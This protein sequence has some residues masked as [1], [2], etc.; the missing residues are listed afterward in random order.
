MNDP[1]S[2]LNASFPY[3]PETILASACGQAYV[4]IMLSSGNIGVCSTLNHPVETDPLL[5]EKPDLKRKDHRMLVTAFAN[6]HINYKQEPFGSGDIFDQVDFSKKKHTVMVGYFPPLVEKFRND[7][8]S[9]AAFDQHRDYPDLKPESD[10]DEELHRSDCVIITATTLINETFETVM[11]KIPADASVYM[12]GPSTT[13]DPAFRKKY[14]IS[15][16]FGMVFNPY[17]FEV[18]EIISKGM[19]TQSFSKKGKKVSL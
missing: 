13:L 16:L 2:V 18:L 4:A 5:L 19:G 17:D 3:D 15:G 8:L 14:N 9:L 6:A 11:A 1:V 7:G 12:L 10:L